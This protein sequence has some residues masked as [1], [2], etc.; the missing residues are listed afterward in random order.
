MKRKRKPARPKCKTK[1]KRPSSLR[2]KLPAGVVLIKAALRR[3]WQWN[4]ARKRVKRA[5][6]VVCGLYRCARCGNCFPKIEID[7]VVPVGAV[8]RVADAPDVLPEETEYDWTAY[9]RR[10]FVGET[11]LQALCHDCHKTKGH[12]D[13][14]KKR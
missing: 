2:A 12:E 13:R 9:I 6:L 7:H 4:V 10:L 11:G 8:E 5:A 14:E 1:R 3:V